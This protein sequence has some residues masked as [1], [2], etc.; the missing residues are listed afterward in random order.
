MQDFLLGFNYLRGEVGAPSAF[1]AGPQ[2][3]APHLQPTA[4]IF[5]YYQYL[6][7]GSSYLALPSYFSASRFWRGLTKLSFAA[8][9]AGYEVTSSEVVA[10]T[11]YSRK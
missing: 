3:L 10:S 5:T 4:K 9:I 7:S 8:T 1:V 11:S 2:I 6:K